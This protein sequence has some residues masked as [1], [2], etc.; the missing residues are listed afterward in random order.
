MVED[1]TV[2]VFPNLPSSEDDDGGKAFASGGGRMVYRGCL[3]SLEG[4]VAIGK[5][6]R[7]SCPGQDLVPNLPGEG[8]ARKEVLHG[9]GLLVAKGAHVVVREAVSE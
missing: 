7:S 2:A 1:T 6:S 8:A 5:A 4:G 9:L 3:P